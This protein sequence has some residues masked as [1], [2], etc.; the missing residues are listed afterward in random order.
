MSFQEI[1]DSP[2]F[3]RALTIAVII[4]FANGCLSCH[5]VLRKSSLVVGAYAH[6]TLP[7]IATA[8][9]LGGVSLINVFIGAAASALL[10]GLGSV[11]LVRH[12]RVDHHSALALMW[13]T[14]AAI[15]LF[16]IDRAG[17]TQELEGWLFGYILTISDQDLWTSFAVSALMMIIVVVLQR[18]LLL[19]HFEPDVAASVGVPVRALHY[20]LVALFVFALVSS[21]QAVGAILAT[22]TLVA[23]ALI[24][25]QLAD[26]PRKVFWGAGLIGGGVA[27]LAILV[28]HLISV[29]P[30]ALI[31]VLLAVAYALAMIFG[32]K[33]G[34]LHRLRHGRPGHH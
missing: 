14:G 16:I 22:S 30:G 1:I 32:N 23:P 18:P 3:W 10:I 8:V 12:S 27:A 24:M 17:A 4:G 5:V 34:L 13:T 28:S 25:T 15:G 31:V 20:L 11:W 21:L 33:Y 19:M 6:G 9:L 26:S 29:R 2:F 7:G